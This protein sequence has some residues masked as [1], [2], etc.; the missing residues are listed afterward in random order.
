MDTLK[1]LGCLGKWMGSV[2]SPVS[3]SAFAGAEVLIWTL[4]TYFAKRERKK[5]EKKIGPA[6]GSL[7]S[8]SGIRLFFFTHVFCTTFS[9]IKA[10]RIFIWERSQFSSTL[11]QND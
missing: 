1:V 8:E 9:F 2:E 4:R 7:E 10:A 11:N 3:K 5:R 6:E